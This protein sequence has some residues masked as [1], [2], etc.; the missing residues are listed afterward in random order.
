M[1]ENAGLTVDPGSRDSEAGLNAEQLNR[2][3]DIDAV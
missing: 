3:K 2:P 1:F